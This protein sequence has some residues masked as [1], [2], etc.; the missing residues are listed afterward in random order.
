MTRPCSYNRWSTADGY[1][2]L[3][4]AAYL[5]TPSDKLKTLWVW[6]IH[7][8]PHCFGGSVK[9]LDFIVFILFLSWRGGGDRIDI[10][11]YK[12]WFNAVNFAIRSEVMIIKG[13]LPGGI[14]RGDEHILKNF[15]YVIFCTVQIFSGLCHCTRTDSYCPSCPWCPVR[16]AWKY[17]KR[18]WW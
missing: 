18:Q 7:S 12:T 2:W 17:L 1:G 16:H 13:T 10:P 3:Y 5:I 11:S 14:N 8:P 4:V 6:G 15:L 9:L